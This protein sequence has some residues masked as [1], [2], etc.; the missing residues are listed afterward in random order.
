MKYL[1]NT[2]SF[3]CLLNIL[4]AITIFLVV[5]PFYSNMPGD[6]LD[7]SWQLWL[8]EAV[9]KKL[10]FG[11]DVIFTFGPYSSLYTKSYHPATDSLIVLTGTLFAVGYI[12]ALFNYTKHIK[13]GYAI[14][15]L[16]FF[17]AF[18]ILRDVLLFSY[19]LLVLLNILDIRDSTVQN[20]Q[21]CK[22][23]H[24]KYIGYT[25]LL[26]STLALVT[27]VK[28]SVLPL[29]LLVLIISFFILIRSKCI[30]LAPISLISFCSS[31]II[32]WVISG[33]LIND[34]P[35]FF[36]SSLPIVF[37][38]T[39]A[40][41]S[42]G[43]I[44]HIVEYVLISVFFLCFLYKS[45][46]LSVK[47]K[48]VL[49]SLA[50]FFLFL[51]YKAGFVRHDGHALAASG[52]LFF[53]VLVY[54]IK[55]KYKHRN[56]II[57]MSFI[58]MLQTYVKYLPHINLYENWINNYKY[59]VAG[60][61]D[62]LFN[63]GGLNNDYNS[64]LIRIREKYQLPS[65]KGTS[66]IYAYNQSAIIASD[67]NWSPRPVAQSYSSYTSSLALLNRDHLV[68]NSPDNIF[69]KV[70]TIDNRLPSPDEK[71]NSA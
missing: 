67:N 19:P 13:Q 45:E 52:F 20:T 46:Y 38:Y 16:I 61:T 7:P 29:V 11:T 24:A 53:N 56:I 30:W 49:S 22:S 58:F 3:E 4:L 2:K 18:L 62:R 63:I 44:S 64:S 37:G 70:E 35:M 32:F 60:V 50:V 43:P 41:A 15:L 21:L 55:Y 23:F 31:L 33:Q 25:F 57:F 9:S 51:A 6:G 10:R 65:L 14:L 71:A 1:S 27:L 8:N 47:L 34:L 59:S 66:D 28:A 40:M 5:V 36:M 17:G 26:F 12:F 54:A 48:L 68:K 42:G 39:E 69:F